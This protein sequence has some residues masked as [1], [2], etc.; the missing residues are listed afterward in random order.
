MCYFF[1]NNVTNDSNSHAVIRSFITQNL[2]WAR[3]QEQ[4]DILFKFMGDLQNKEHLGSTLPERFIR[5]LL[6]T[7][8]FMWLSN[9]PLTWLQHNK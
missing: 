4:F 5:H 8:S 1:M 6:Y 3:A 9:Q 7:Y 2:I